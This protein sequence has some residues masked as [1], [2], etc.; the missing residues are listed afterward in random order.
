MSTA[1]KTSPTTAPIAPIIRTVQ[2]KAPPPRAFELFTRHMGKWWGK[3]IGKNPPVDVIIEP[4]VGGRWYERDADGNEAHWGKVLAWQP[5]GRLL[6]AWQITCEWGY[7]P[8]LLTELELTFAASADGG[9]L[10]TLEHRNLERFGTD[11]ARHVERLNGGW[12]TKLA[13]FVAF[14][15]TGATTAPDGPCPASRT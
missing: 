1:I 13:T 7:D 4:R 8:Q 6:L 12:P 14:A 11:A 5:P 2:V 9:T 15:D 3:G 10:V